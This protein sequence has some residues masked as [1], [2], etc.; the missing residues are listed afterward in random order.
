MIPRL[1][2][3]VLAAALVAL[4]AAVPAHA[5]PLGAPV[6]IA[7]L[8]GGTS[9]PSISSVALA[10]DGTTAIAG[11]VSAAGGRRVVAGVG[12]A[13]VF[14]RGVAGGI[15]SQPVVA[16]RGGGDGA[17]V[18][19]MGHRVLLSLCD[20]GR[21]A[22][23]VQVG[24]SR[25]SPDAQVAIDPAS[26]RVTVLWRG[27][28]SGKDRLQ[29]RITTGGR[30]GPVHTLGEFGSS[31]KIGTDASGKSIAVWLGNG[32][33]RA[34][35][36]RKGEF[37][38]P[39]TIATGAVQGLRLDVASSGQTIAAWRAPAPGGADVQSP[40]GT[41]VSASRTR[42][43]GFGPGQAVTGVADAGTLDV[44]INDNGRAVLAFDRQADDVTAT[45]SAA[46]RPGAGVPFGPAVALSTPQFVSE[47]WGSFAAIDD[48]GMATV[49]WGGAATVAAARSD[50]NGVFGAAQSLAPINSGQSTAVLA[51]AAG[52]S[53][54]VAW[55]DATG[56]WMSTGS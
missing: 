17:V 21:C 32:G 26:G 53:T 46:Y 48:N 12:S 24:S 55:A 10:P 42:D 19:G 5:A 54:F 2:L 52:A 20:E 41:P 43:T 30:L 36:R 16:V 47:A 44:A 45:V 4:G 15:L 23:P 39:T 34:S 9:L 8:P 27:T 29:W 49:S 22:T 18:W 14:P 37:L 7:G 51:A 35:A 33:V 25:L 11:T 38:R 13:Q 28:T 40:R 56:G 3:P 1:G 6:R 50:V 31:P